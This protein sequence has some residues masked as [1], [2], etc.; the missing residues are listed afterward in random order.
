[1]GIYLMVERQEADKTEPALEIGPF[2]FQKRLKKK[3]LNGHLL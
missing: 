3:R 1:M 2:Y